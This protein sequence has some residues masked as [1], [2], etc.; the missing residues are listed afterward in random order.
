MNDF[1]LNGWRKHSAK[2]NTI[3]K[4]WIQKKQRFNRTNSTV[5]YNCLTIRKKT[6]KSLL[7]TCYSCLS[8][9][10]LIC[11]P[12]TG[13]FNAHSLHLFITELS[14]YCTDRKTF[15]QGHRCMH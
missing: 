4:V 2:I 3:Y 14:V 13:I 9:S 1:A 7:V 6:S 10:S 15:F 8:K 12:V 11:S 5:K